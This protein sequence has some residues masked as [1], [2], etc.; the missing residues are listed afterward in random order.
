LA[1]SRLFGSRVRVDFLRLADFDLRCTLSQCR[2]HGGVR[3]ACEVYVM[4]GAQS[5]VYD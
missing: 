4:V 2:A 5:G 3:A 1:P